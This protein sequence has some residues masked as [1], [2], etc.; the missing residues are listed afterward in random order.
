MNERKEHL[1]SLYSDIR[2]AKNNLLSDSKEERNKG[3]FELG[4]IMAALEFTI[5]DLKEFEE[6]E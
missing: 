2:R 3:F 1:L 4:L 5:D 6:G